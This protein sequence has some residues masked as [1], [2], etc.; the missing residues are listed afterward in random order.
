MAEVRNKDNYEQ[1]VK[2]FL[3]AFYESAKDATETIDKLTALHEKNSA[4]SNNLGRASISANKVFAYLEANP[5]IEIRKTAKSLGM[6][7]NTVSSAVG[8]LVDAGILVHSNETS[9][10]R[11]FAYSEYLGILRGG[12]E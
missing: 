5:I 12:T 10:N 1:W 3:Q 11:T 8:R 2:F 7:F 9:R 6:A 4:V